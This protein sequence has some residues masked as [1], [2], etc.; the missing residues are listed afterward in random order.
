MGTS[1]P[2][3]TSCSQKGYRSLDAYKVQVGTTRA[4]KSEI[5]TL[6]GAQERREQLERQL[7]SLE[8]ASGR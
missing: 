8:T 7:R 3:A 1:A 4:L 2:C 6:E 5:E